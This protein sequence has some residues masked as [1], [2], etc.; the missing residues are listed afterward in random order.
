MISVSGCCCEIIYDP[1]GIIIIQLLNFS[2]IFLTIN[3]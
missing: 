3:I 2:I 1:I